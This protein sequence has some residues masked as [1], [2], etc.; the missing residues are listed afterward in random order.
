MNTA[1]LCTRP[2]NYLEQTETH[3]HS[4]THICAHMC[5]HVHAR[6]HTH[7]HTHTHTFTHLHCSSEP[8]VFR[9][10]LAPDTPQ[11]HTLSI[12]LPVKCIH[13]I[14]H[15]YRK[16]NKSVCEGRTPSASACR[17]N[18]STSLVT[19]TANATKVCVRDAHPQHLLAGAVHPP[20]LSPIA[21]TKQKC[22]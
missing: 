6:T 10:S 1:H 3:A 7:T 2:S 17:C 18:A 4:H 5:T 19:Y 13:L 14:C 20:H 9:L 22:V 15:L 8:S 21:Q 11:A 12:C 16:R